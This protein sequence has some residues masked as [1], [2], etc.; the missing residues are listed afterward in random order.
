VDE[1]VNR[2][3]VAEERI[4]AMA[5]LAGIAGLIVLIG[6]CSGMLTLG[7]A[8][9]PFVDTSLFGP[10][11]LIGIAYGFLVIFATLIYLNRME[12]TFAIPVFCCASLPS[13]VVASAALMW[14]HGAPPLRGVDLIAANAVSDPAASFLHRPGE[15]RPHLTRASL[16]IG[17]CSEA[18]ARCGFL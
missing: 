3:F 16:A 17:V 6:A 13:G 14:L 8:F 1:S 4:V 9:T 2:R 5:A 18:F 15:W 7:C 12:N 11:L 10:A